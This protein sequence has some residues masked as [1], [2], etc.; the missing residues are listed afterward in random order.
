V[1]NRL[2]SGSILRFFGHCLLAASAGG[3]L[4]SD[5]EIKTCLTIKVLFGLQLRQTTGCVESLLRLV[6]LDG[7]VPDFNALCRRQRTLNVSLPYRGCIAPL[8]QLKESTGI[9]AEGEGE[10]QPSPDLCYKAPRKGNF[11]K[12]AICALQ[13]SGLRRG[14]APRLTC[15]H[16]II[17]SDRRTA[18]SPFTTF[19][20]GAAV[21][22]AQAQRAG[23]G[24]SLLRGEWTVAMARRPKITVS[25]A[26]RRDDGD[27]DTS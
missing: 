3:S 19:V 26:Q 11:A 5:G 22:G 12:V 7:V 25:A 15:S 14:P 27:D 1:A 23:S 8:N 6:G 10:D 9:K 20:P 2:K 17:Q 13:P 24:H 16:L 18:A 4:N 21:A